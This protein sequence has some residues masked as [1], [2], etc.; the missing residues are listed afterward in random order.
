M[1]V[2]VKNVLFPIKGKRDV[3]LRF[4]QQVFTLC[5]VMYSDQLHRNLIPGPQ[6]DLNGLSF[7]GCN[8]EVKICRGDEYLSN[9][10]LKNRIYQ[11]YPKIPVS[12][13]KSVNFN[14]FQLRKKTML[15]SIRGMATSVSLL[16]HILVVNM[17]Y[18]GYQA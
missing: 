18:E 12:S 2:A 17:V 6:L 1:S 7:Y 10:Y 13:S 4:G 15:H 8:S 11:L 3:K 5:N 9:A 14:L 16:L